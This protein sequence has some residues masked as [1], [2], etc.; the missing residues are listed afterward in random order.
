M[1]ERAPIEVRGLRVGDSHRRRVNIGDRP[2]RVC[3]LSYR[4][5]P[6][7]GGQ[8]VYIKNLSQALKGLGHH[9]EVVSGPPGV[10]LDAGIPVIKPPCLDLYNPQDLFR[11]PSL[12]ELANP[13]NLVEWLSVC[14]MG[15]PEPF[16]FGLRALLVLRR[17]FGKYDVVHDN[18]C[19]SYGLLAIKRFVPTVATIHH[20]ITIDRD[21]ALRE[22]GTLRRR[23]QIMR[24]YSFIGMQKRVSR[25]LDRIITVSRKAQEDISREFGISEDRLVVAPNGVDTDL[26][27]P[28]P[29]IERDKIRIMV[30]N[31][32]DI[33][34]KGLSYLLRAIKKVSCK[35]EVKLVVIGAPKHNGRVQRLVQELGIQEF[36]TFTGRVTSD[37]LVT[38]YARSLMAVVPSLYEGFGLPAVEAMACGVA[39]VS[40]TGGALPEVVGDAGVL[41][42]AGD[43]AALALALSELLSYPERAMELG[44]RGYKRVL[45]HFT[46]EQAAI[47]TVQAYQE[48]IRAYR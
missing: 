27:R 9:V 4:T 3:L 12:R 5:N 32:S 44:R 2:L 22:A 43:S 34:L 28:I 10:E 24:W 33:P 18:Q 20:P 45:R 41:V 7:C 46:W 8:G 13:I 6:H 19:L 30:T 38:H 36:V 29:G 37:E 14:T 42:P 39:V 26:F 40:T 21:T 16:T 25:R 23:A 48:A 35:R 31:S 17:R 1:T 15:F 11:V 47:K